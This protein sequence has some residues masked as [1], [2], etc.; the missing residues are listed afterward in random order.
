M[1]SVVEQVAKSRGESS[2]MDM[3]RAEIS[4]VV[5]G[6]ASEVL[7]AD[8]ILQAGE[9]EFLNAISGQTNSMDANVQFIQ[10]RMVAWKNASSTIPTFF[11]MTV[12][13]DLQHQTNRAGQLLEIIQEIGACASMSDKGDVGDVEQ[14]AIID[15]ILYLEVF[16]TNAHRAAKEPA[17]HD[18]PKDVLIQKTNKIEQ[19]QDEPGKDLDEL[20]TELSNLVGLSLVKQDVTGL[21]NLIRVRKMRQERGMQAPPLSL[22]LV[23][24]GNPGTG[25]TT[26]A[27]LLAKIYRAMGLLSKGHL[28]E[29]DRSGLVAG[30]VGQTAIKVRELAKT[31]FGGI[32]FIDEAYSLSSS[33]SE[34][35]YGREAIDTLLKLMEDK[36]E[37]FVVIAAGYTEEMR[38]FLQSN[39]GLQSRFNKFIHFEDYCPQELYDIFVKFCTDNGYTYDVACGRLVAS[40]LKSQYEV[41]EEHF[42]NARSVRNLFE[43]TIS[44]HANRVAQLPGPSEDDLRTIIIDDLPA[45]SSFPQ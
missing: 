7:S 16:A 23:F 11:S 44:N 15:Y 19:R 8:G 14:E 18:G 42:G 38:S 5:F 28:I 45:G 37:D 36:R 17:G 43:H 1:C 30:Y 31:A 32:L 3:L 4:D 27:R 6:L 21:I 41:R 12:L 20:I 39:P 40:L 24:S 26:V 2:K 13:Y 29:T 25:K 9:S 34:N 35:D 22:H 10:D 33:K